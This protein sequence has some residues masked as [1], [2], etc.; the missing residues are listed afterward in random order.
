[1][2]G[3]HPVE[4]FVFTSSLFF[5]STLAVCQS[6]RGH[7]QPPGK[8]PWKSEGTWD[9]SRPGRSCEQEPAV[10]LLS[11]GC[12]RGV[13]GGCLRHTLVACQKSCIFHSWFLL[14]KGHFLPA[15]WPGSWNSVVL[16]SSVSFPRLL[17]VAVISPTVRASSASALKTWTISVL[18]WT[19]WLK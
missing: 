9:L 14:K 17:W 5:K 1:M 18:Y 8:R 15:L 13:L 16:L 19:H 10:A 2:A 4:R 6:C 7:K 12:E 3:A 11:P